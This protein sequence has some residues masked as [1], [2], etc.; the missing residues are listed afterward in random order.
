MREPQLREAAAVGRAC[1]ACLSTDLAG[2]PVVRA[3]RFFRCRRCLSLVADTMPSHDVVS[4]LYERPEYFRNPDFDA[5][6][7]G[8]FH[9]YKDYIAD[10]EH[11]EEKFAAILE[12]IEALGGAGRL[13]DVGAGPGFLVSAACARGWEAVGVEPNPWAA[14]LGREHGLDIRTGVLADRTE[15]EPGSFDAVSFMDVIEHVDHPDELVATAHSLLRPGGVLALLTADAGSPISRALGRRWPEVQRYPE[16]LILFSVRGLAEL[17]ARHGFE[18]AG[19]HSVGKR[20]SLATLA[21]DVSPIAPRLGRVAAR[22]LAGSRFGRRH[23]ELDPHV[24]FCLYAR[25]TELPYV[26]FTDAPRLSKRPP[27]R[28]AVLEDLDVL[29]RAANLCDWMFD[30]IPAAAGARVAEVGAGIGT[31]S[32]RLLRAGAASLLLV[33]PD[34][35]SAAVLEGRFSHDERVTVVREQLPGAPALVAGSFDLVVCQNVL[36]HI[37]E[38]EEALAAIA[39]ALAPGGTLFLLVP[40]HPSL[41]GRLDEEYGH[42]RRYTRTRVRELLAAAELEPVHVSPFD[43]PGALAWWASGRLGASGI[44]PA[45]LRIFDRIVPT[46]R[47]IEARLPL[48]FGLSIVADARKLR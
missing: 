35:E 33:E 38:E 13:L 27:R 12:R 30:Q 44:N 17:V 1:P 34:E 31:F 3:H 22:A 5:P 19:R 40:A 18:V 6:D 15:L 4:R 28:A 39:A 23:F 48:P 25:K 41:F 21:A 7:A 14:E 37:A 29:G 11:I 16:H 47:R 42:H 2:G 26:A 46:W 9:G 36:E 45:A 43:A 10:R 32:E 20:S 8:G 24:K